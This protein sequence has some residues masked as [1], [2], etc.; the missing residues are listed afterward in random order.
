MTGHLSDLDS[1]KQRQLRKVEQHERVAYVQCGQPVLPRR[2]RLGWQ[3]FSYALLL[4]ASRGRGRVIEELPRQ[5][6]RDETELPHELPGLV[7]GG[8]DK[9]QRE[10]QEPL[11]SRARSQVCSPSLSSAATSWTA[12]RETEQPRWRSS[13][14]ARSRRREGESAGDGACE[15]AE[16]AVI[17]K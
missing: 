5:Q 15:P 9:E 4:L 11:R 8:R 6:Q 1:G 2:L 13:R 7:G 10:D 12:Q 3:H 16:Q 14:I 17:K